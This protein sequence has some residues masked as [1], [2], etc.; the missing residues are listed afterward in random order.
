MGERIKNAWPAFKDIAIVFSF[1]V[2]LVLVLVLLLLVLFLLTPI[3]NDIAMPLLGNLDTAFMHLGEA[4]IQDKITINQPVPV[5]FTLPLETETMVVLTRPVPLNVPATFSLGQFGRIQGNVSLQLPAG[6]TLPVW[7]DLDVPVDKQITVAFE[8]PIDI[9]LGK[10][11][12]AGVV[13]ELRGVLAPYLTL[14]KKLP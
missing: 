11:G 2:N 1:I 13:G 5:K 7:L 14:L 10:A 3:K 12:L 8:Q 6:L 9:E 4:H